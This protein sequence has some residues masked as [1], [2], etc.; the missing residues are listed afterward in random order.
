MLEDL[1]VI[2]FALLPERPERVVRAIGQVHALRAR[3]A[4][5][6][7]RQGLFARFRGAR[8]TAAAA[9]AL[10]LHEPDALPPPPLA[11]ADMGAFGPPEAALRVSHPVGS[12]ALTLVEFREIDAETS[13]LCE[14]LSAELP[15][16]EI[17]RFRL[18][19]GRHPGAETA[20]HVYLDGRAVRRAASISAEGIAPEAPWRAV[21]SGMPHA[22]EAESLPSARAR[23]WEIMT[24]ARQAA[25]LGALGVDADALFEPDPSL[26]AR[27]LTPAPGGAPLRTAA[28]IFA[29]A[30]RPGPL[31]PP[32]RQ[33]G[34]R[35]EEADATSWE[36]EV[37]ALLVAAVT[38]ALPERERVGWLTHL[39][40]R[41]EAGDV[42]R[43][44]AEAR[45]LLARGDRPAQE[46]DADIA[47]LDAL[48][49]RGG[50][51]A[52]DGPGGTGRA[53][54]R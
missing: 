29:D 28:G 11:R 51:P 36:A 15:G 9:P 17:F 38:H 25:I 52:D 35:A 14:A 54:R 20:F 40:A 47:R 8:S 18:S 32:S 37:T 12:A 33:D 7:P 50:G 31:A 39:T 5:R 2:D 27:A 10:T 42:D 21:D 30:G 19:G 49:G 23:A 22:V 4:A 6:S 53:G 46:R 48:F 16:V 1:A 34:A 13:P 43:A 24:P 41:L 3:A 44:L 45:D 26:R